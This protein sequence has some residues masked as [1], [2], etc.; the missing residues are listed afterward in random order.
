MIGDQDDAMQVRCQALT[1]IAQKGHGDNW[2]RFV[3]LGSFRQRANPKSAE[4]SQF[5]KTNPIPA[6]VRFASLGLVRFAIFRP[7][8]FRPQAS[9]FLPRCLCVQVMNFLAA[10]RQQAIHPVSYIH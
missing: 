4:Q 6:S 9:L 3:T 8:P 5:D 10:L 2:V 1:P 7:A